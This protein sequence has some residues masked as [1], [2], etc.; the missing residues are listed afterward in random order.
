VS[1][2]G[3]KRSTGAWGFN[4][5]TRQR[6][7]LARVSLGYDPSA[8]RQKQGKVGRGR[9]GESGL[10]GVKAGEGGV[11]GVRHLGRTRHGGPGWR[12][13]RGRFHRGT[14]GAG[15]IARAGMSGGRLP[16]S[17]TSRRAST[18]CRKGS[19]D[20]PL[21]LDVNAPSEVV[22]VV[23]RCSCTTWLARLLRLDLT[24]TR[25]E[26]QRTR[27][28]LEIEA[29]LTISLRGARPRPTGRRTLP[30]VQSAHGRV[31]A[32][33]R[34]RAPAADSVPFPPGWFEDH[35]GEVLECGQPQVADGRRAADAPWRG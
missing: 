23:Q 12:T 2:L 32:A 27:R 10:C 35:C 16:I 34:W 13:I 8:G 14:V 11:V 24:R 19:S 31:S 20:F 21:I 28:L 25:P 18:V 30:C 5:S 6:L 26:S 3:L 15:G 1:R 33:A 29:P 22:A 7:Y 9:T 4:P 17:A